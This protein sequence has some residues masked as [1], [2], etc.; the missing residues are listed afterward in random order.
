MKNLPPMLATEE[1]EVMESPAAPMEKAAAMSI[2]MPANFKL[3]DGKKEGETFEVIAKMCQ[4]GDKL[5][6][7]SIDGYESEGEKKMEAE[8][9]E[10]EP[11]HDTD[12]DFAAELSAAAKQMR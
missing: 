8:K 4:K 6:I 5:E 1:E 7:E 12:D 2:P 11:G 9:K 3:P 10:M